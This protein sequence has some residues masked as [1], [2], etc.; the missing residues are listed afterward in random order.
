M[1]TI[2]FRLR[3]FLLDREGALDVCF[4]QL[5]LSFLRGEFLL[6][7]P[8]RGRHKYGVACQNCVRSNQS[9]KHAEGNFFL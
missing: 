1:L 4:E 8:S 9:G 6:R 7:R 2:R 5:L 3:H